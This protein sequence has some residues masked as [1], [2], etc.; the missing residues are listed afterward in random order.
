MP[1]PGVVLEELAPGQQGIRVDFKPTPV[2]GEFINDHRMITG[3][4]GPLG[5][6]K[7]TGGVQKAYQYAQAFPG[8]KVAVIRDTW[9]NLRDTTQQSFF[10]WFPDGIAGHYHATEKRFELWTNRRARPSQILFRAL[11]DAKDIKN[12]LSLELA[13]AW[14]D[15][16]QGGPTATGGNDPGIAA[17]LFRSLFARVGRQAGYPLK[18]IWLTG[19]PPPPTH[20]I[21]EEFNYRGV[22]P[23]PEGDVRHKLYLVDRDENRANLHPTYYEDLEAV[24]GVNT[25]LARRFIKG[26][27]IPFATMQ[28]FHEEWFLEWRDTKDPADPLALP[29]HDL[30]F[31]EG[32]VDPAIS[33]NDAAASSAIYVAGQC[34]H[35]VNRGRIY[36]LFADKGHWS[37]YETVHRLIQ[38]YRQ[39]GLR[40]VS[41]E[42]VAYQ[43]VLGEVLEY[44]ARTAGVTIHVVLV[45]PDADKV[46]RAN[47]WAPLVEQGRW[48]IAPGMMGLRRAM[49][50]VPMDKTQWDL[51]DAAGYC[52]RAFPTLLPEAQRL[53]GF[54]VSTSKVAKSYATRQSDHPWRSEEEILRKAIGMPTASGGRPSTDRARGYSPRHG[55][56][57]RAAR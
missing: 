10:D 17:D 23:A 45:P 57:K 46:R 40:R 28:P 6:A 9:P 13:A 15:E 19:N 52:V 25:P 50:A 24:W 41:I 48:L 35:G 43:A 22:G 39:Y 1:A 4:F 29:P 18:M 54:E 53:P 26:E 32:A 56:G 3:C 7:T 27:W 31:V 33:K 21:A 30:M 44:E 16:P 42:K 8:A 5:T 38:V 49:T 47:A 2:I 20:W 34:Q 12:V 14:L 51:V 36:T 55:G 11:D 37:A